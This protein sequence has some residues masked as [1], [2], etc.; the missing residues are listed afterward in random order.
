MREA[1]AAMADELNREC[2]TGAKDPGI[3]YSLTYDPDSAH[4]NL[5]RVPR[6][7]RGR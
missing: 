4:G 7:A 2:M 3:G 5:G 6:S 1:I